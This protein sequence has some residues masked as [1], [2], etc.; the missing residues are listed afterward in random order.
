MLAFYSRRIKQH[1]VHKEFTDY[2][3]FGVWC[4]ES[5]KNS[6]NGSKYNTVDLM[7][8]K[9]LSVITNAKMGIKGFHVKRCQA[10]RRVIL[11]IPLSSWLSSSLSSR[12]FSRLDI[13]TDISDKGDRKTGVREVWS[14]P[15]Q[16]WCNIS[17]STPLVHSLSYKKDRHQISSN[18]FLPTNTHQT[19]KNWGKPIQVNIAFQ[20]FHL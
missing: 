9:T 10:G 14:N 19:L 17:L 11:L 18:H 3:P 20:S 7:Y 4:T 5:V 1:A 13:R 6:I 15:E 16:I 12:S 2:H 8:I